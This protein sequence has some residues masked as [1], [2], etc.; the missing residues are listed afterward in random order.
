MKV[1]FWVSKVPD[2]SYEEITF[3]DCYVFSENE[4]QEWYNTQG[5][6][7]NPAHEL[8]S[9]K[10]GSFTYKTTTN[11]TY[12][13]VFDNYNRFWLGITF[14]VQFRHFEIS[15]EAFAWTWVV[16]GGITGLCV[17]G[18]WY[19]LRREPVRKRKHSKKK[20]KRA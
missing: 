19:G 7:C 18:V 2:P 13:C 17:V 12:Y 6:T 14:D 10:E 11:G 3:I 5:E 8:R 20:R 9:V 4:Y 15:G 16:V 1:N